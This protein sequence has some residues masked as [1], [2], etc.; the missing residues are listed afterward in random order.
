LKADEPIVSLEFVGER[1]RTKTKEL[2][3]ISETSSSCNDEQNATQIVDAR[4]KKEKEKREGENAER[5]M[6][7]M[8]LAK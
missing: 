1:K 2:L 3:L 8:E 7:E 4:L 5:A 6:I